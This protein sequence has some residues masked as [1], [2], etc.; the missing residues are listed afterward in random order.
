[1]FRSQSVR[2]ILGFYLGTTLDSHQRLHTRLSQHIGTEAVPGGF[3]SPTSHS[4]L[5]MCSLGR[6]VEVRRLFSLYMYISAYLS[7]VRVIVEFIHITHI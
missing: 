3:T 2:E 1:M 5:G 6:R 4:L 7:L